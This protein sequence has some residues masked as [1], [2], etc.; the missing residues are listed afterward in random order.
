MLCDLCHNE[1]AHVH[2]SATKL[3]EIKSVHL[4]DV[5]AKKVG[6]LQGDESRS[7]GTLVPPPEKKLTMDDFI[8]ARVEPDDKT[9]CK[10]GSGGK[11]K[12]KGE[13]DQKVVAND[14][15]RL[16]RIGVLEKHLQD[17]VKQERFEECLAVKQELN[18][19]K[20]ANPKPAQTQHPVDAKLKAIKI[21]NREKQLQELI[22]QEK[23]EECAKV[24]DEIN[25]LKNQV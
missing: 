25:T 8:E 1:E 2:R 7:Q 17:F 15:V 23:Y 5:C 18:M 6:L 13:P 14:S 24:R 3:G 12:A 16:D 21:R 22:K 4:C 11:Q 20:G 9:V 19:L 10:K